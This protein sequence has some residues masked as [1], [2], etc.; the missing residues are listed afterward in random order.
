MCYSCF[1]I[2]SLKEEL[3]LSNGV[4]LRVEALLLDAAL[5]KLKL[6]Y[7]AGYERMML[8]WAPFC[9]SSWMAADICIVGLKFDCC[10]CLFSFCH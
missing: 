4:N 3:N 7:D 2:G 8:L 1:E 6:S 9:C 5:L 10:S